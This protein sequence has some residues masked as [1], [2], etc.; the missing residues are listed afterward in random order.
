MSRL[1]NTLRRVV[2]GGIVDLYRRKKRAQQRRQL[3]DQRDAGDVINK[4][5]LIADLRNMGIQE[6]D[7]VLFHSSLSK[8]GYIEGGA[9][10]VIQALLSVIGPSGNLMMPSSPNPALQLDYIRSVEIFDVLHTPSAMGRVSEV[11]RCMPGV[12]RSAHPTEPVCVL[13]PDADYLTE[14]HLGEIT[15]Y[16]KRSP[17]YRLYEKHGKILYA[18]VTLDNAGTN[19]HTLEDAVDFPY[20]VYYNEEFTVKM[21]KAD[22]EEVVVK[23]KVHNPEFSKK[24]RCDELLPIFENEGV[25]SRHKLGK[26]DVLVFDGCGMFNTMVQEFNS[27]QVTM[28][29]P[30]GGAL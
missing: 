20:P 30:N 15:P 7:T 11:F 25:M 17:F 13:G 14:G 9:E 29:T 16:A 10:S 12:K 19:L 21:R 5:H 18:G 22:G 28:Y 1:R 24:R 8:L 27:K 2:P 6:G 26:A 4:G 23:T 3:E